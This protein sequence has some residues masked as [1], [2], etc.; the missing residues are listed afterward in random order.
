MDDGQHVVSLDGG[1]AYIAHPAGCQ[2]PSA[3]PFT[4][5]AGKLP[6]PMLATGGTWTCD[7]NDGSLILLKR[8]AAPT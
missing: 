2:D 6:P 4:A 7:L 3:C 5:A 1:N 8:I